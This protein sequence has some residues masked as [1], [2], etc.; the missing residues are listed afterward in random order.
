MSIGSGSTLTN[1]LSSKIIQVNGNWTNSGVFIHGSGTVL[2]GS[3]SALQAIGG[4]STTTFNILTMNGAGVKRLDNNIN[5]QGDFTVG[6]TTPS[7]V[8][9]TLNLNGRNVD[10]SGVNF[11]VLVG[12]SQIIRGGNAGTFNF[13]RSGNQTVSVAAT[14]IK[15]FNNLKKS[16][17]G[18]LFLNSDIDVQNDLTI[19]L[20]TTIDVTLSNRA[21]NLAG[22]WINNGTFL[23]RSGVVGFY[24]SNVS[25]SKSS[26]RQVFFTLI[27][28]TLSNLTLNV[29]V[30]VQYALLLDRNGII[31]TGSNSIALTSASTFVTRTAS[32]NG[33]YVDGNLVKTYSSSA[34][35]YT[36]EVGTAGV[37]TPVTITPTANTTGT[38]TVKA[39][40]GDSPNI[41]TSCFGAAKSVNRYW[42][43]TKTISA[44]F[45]A[46]FNYNAAVTDGGVV[47]ANLGLSSYNGSWT[48]IAPVPTPTAT[49]L[50]AN[51]ISTTGDFQI[52]ESAPSATIVSDAPSNTICTGTN[53]V[54]SSTSVNGGASPIYQWTLNGSPVGTN[55]STYSNASLSNGAQVR[56]ALT[57]ACPIVA[58][59]NIITMTVNPIPT[60]VVSGAD[61]ICDGTSTTLTASGASTYVWTSGP[62]TPT[63]LVSPTSTTTYTV[64]GTSLGCSNTGNKILNVKSKPIVVISGDTTICNG[65]STTLTASGAVSY[66]WTAGPSSASYLVSPTTNTSYTVTGTGSNSCTN[67]VSK[68]V[69]VTSMSYVWRTGNSDAVWGNGANWSC[70]VVPGSGSDVV[71]PGVAVPYPVISGSTAVVRG[72]EIQFPGTLEVSGTDT[73]EV[74]GNWVNGGTFIPN[75]GTVEFLGTSGQS[76]TNSNTERFHNLTVN[77]S[78]GTLTV[79]ANTEISAIGSGTLSVLSGTLH[80]A[81]GKTVTLKSAE[82]VNQ[83][84]QTARLGRVGG[85]ITPGSVFSVERF[86]GSPDARLPYVYSSNGRPAPTVMLAS[87]LHGVTAAQWSDDLLVRYRA[88]GSTLV[89]YSELNGT[90]A[91]LQERIDGG[92][93]SVSSSGTALSPGKGYRVFAGLD[94]TVDTV[95]VSGTPVVGNHFS[96]VTYSATGTQG[97]NLLGNPYACEI[98]FDDLYAAN[99][100]L[101]S[102]S[103]YIMDP[104]NTG[105]SGT[106]YDNLSYLVY[107]SPSG[108]V[109]DPRTRVDGT[110]TSRTAANAKFIASSQGFFVNATGNGSVYFSESMK[111]LSPYSTPVYGNFREESRELVRLGYSDSLG[112]GEAVV[113]FNAGAADGYDIY[114]ALSLSSTIYTTVGDRKLSING[115][116]SLSGNLRIP[117]V[118]SGRVLGRK[119]ITVSEQTLVGGQLYLY[120]DYRKVSV[121]LDRGAS[122]GFEHTSDPGSTSAS[123]FVLT[124][125]R[126]VVTGGGE[127]STEVSGGAMSIHPNPYV[128]GVLTLGLAGVDSPV[129]DV[130]VLDLGG[131]VVYLGRL[132]SGPRDVSSFELDVSSLGLSS[133]VYAV[134]CSTPTRTF[135]ERLVV[136]K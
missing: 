72:L 70:G 101:I 32:L 33:N 45:N 90:G 21:L 12:T 113:H 66:V 88:S 17:A 77:K 86:I 96:P 80:V 116:R 46:T 119:S 71:V 107:N 108:I 35:A 93:R 26:G 75:M 61:S 49:S 91:T 69:V 16:V 54:F 127:P 104:Y 20:G 112:A 87:P 135:T 111:P 31:T 131:N 11:R 109:S 95:S 48:Y 133:G 34:G 30:D 118:V 132:R 128:G 53:V 99:A 68:L 37:Y 59:S 121:R 79:G 3:G 65:G 85:T 82:P 98:N 9:S 105:S 50:T 89:S 115:L 15:A 130:E 29:G 84:D 41:G 117:L 58:N 8:A 124:T 92:W 5:V 110:G 74:Y 23:S 122:Y 73:L 28:G 81:S 19:D 10:F 64:T 36:F 136:T 52:G 126:P 123:R 94:N 44:N 14:T 97:W 125:A 27:A 103:M 134:R 129:V 13:N 6:Q 67:S 42:N 24:G 22:N 55:S 7:S 78:S 1:L 60:I 47:P 100:G 114:D 62:S 39:F 57:N 2:F 40:N 83:V 18:T 25:I 38:V 51:A 102:S 76:I 106:S 120:D 63:Y 4:T 56:L 43:I